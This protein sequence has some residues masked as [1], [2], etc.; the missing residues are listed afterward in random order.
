MAA[1]REVVDRFG[2]QAGDTSREAMRRAFLTSSRYEYLFWDMAYR[3]EQWP[4]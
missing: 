1:W 3:R 4:V 2:S